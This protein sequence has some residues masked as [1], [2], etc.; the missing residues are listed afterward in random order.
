V[1]TGEYSLRYDWLYLACAV[2][3]A[4]LSEKRQRRAFFYAGVLNTGAAL[5]RIA[6]HRDWF[7]K[8]AWAVAVITAGLAALALGFE[9]DRRQ[10]RGLRG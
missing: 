4:L 6:D 5:V 7:D 1:H 10:R 3:I 9:L 8:P 2:A